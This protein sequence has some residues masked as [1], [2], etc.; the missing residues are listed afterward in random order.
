MS[1][2]EIEATTYKNWKSSQQTSPF[3]AR[4]FLRSYQKY[5]TCDNDYV[6]EN[7]EGVLTEHRTFCSTGN[8][9]LVIIHSYSTFL[10]KSPFVVLQYE[11]TK[12]QGIPLLV[13]YQRFTFMLGLGNKN[14]LLE[15]C[16][17]CMD[18]IINLINKGYVISNKRLALRTILIQDPA[19]FMYVKDITN[20]YRREKQCTPKALDTLGYLNFNSGLY[21]VYGQDDFA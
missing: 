20:I 6:H 1:L 7:K 12:A 17:A 15:L 4:E 19:K 16:K 5:T 18:Q 13:P 2:R 11:T 14:S 9:F 8:R 21:C 10:K 3:R